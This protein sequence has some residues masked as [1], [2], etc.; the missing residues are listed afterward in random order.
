MKKRGIRDEMGKST[1]SREW[2]AR[3]YANLHGMKVISTKY[4][5]NFRAGKGNKEIMV[6]FTGTG[7]KSLRTSVES[8]LR[9]LQTHYIDL[10]SAVQVIVRIVCPANMCI[11]WVVALRPLVGLYDHHRRTHAV[12][13]QLDRH[14]L[15]SLPR[16][17]RH[18]IL[19]CCVSWL[20]S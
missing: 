7:S 2:V 15:G 20:C 13:Q 4:T 12:P 14:W 6:N 10:V 17:K 1:S 19:Y 9:H 5:T 11:V 16:S 8:S 18:A 3:D